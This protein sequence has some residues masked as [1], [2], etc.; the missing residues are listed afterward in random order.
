MGG[1]PN[2]ASAPNTTRNDRAP[3][4][5]SFHSGRMGLGASWQS[6]T[7]PPS[8]RMWM[9]SSRSSSSLAAWAVPVHPKRATEGEGHPAQQQSGSHDDL[10]R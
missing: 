4:I 8:S 6:S 5:S 7:S 10:S 1:K 2:L 3:Q 9:H